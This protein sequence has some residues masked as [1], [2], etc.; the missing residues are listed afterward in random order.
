MTVDCEIV[1]VGRSVKVELYG[2]EAKVFAAGIVAGKKGN[3][4]PEGTL[5]GPVTG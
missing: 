2:P 1:A 3:V 4:K 5:L